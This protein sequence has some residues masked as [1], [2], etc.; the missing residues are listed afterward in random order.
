MRHSYS[1]FNGFSRCKM[2]YA[3]KAIQHP[4]FLYSQSTSIF[5]FQI[6]SFNMQHSCLS[7]QFWHS[8][9]MLLRRV[10]YACYTIQYSSL[11]IELHARVTWPWD[12]RPLDKVCGLKIIACGVPVGHLPGDIV[13]ADSGNSGKESTNNAKATLRR[14]AEQLLRLA[15]RGRLLVLG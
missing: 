9:C 3:S 15:N 6:S 11:D 10:R 4:C 1:M 5:C 14:V 13:M 2:R 12:G 7:M 8:V